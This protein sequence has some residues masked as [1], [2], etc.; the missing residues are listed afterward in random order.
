MDCFGEE[1]PVPWFGPRMVCTSCGIIGAFAR[2]NWQ[3]RPVGESVTGKQW[4]YP[5]TSAPGPD[6]P[7][8]LRDQQEVRSEPSQ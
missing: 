7:L 2:P 6:G 8:R 1:V 4:R 3:E 5:N